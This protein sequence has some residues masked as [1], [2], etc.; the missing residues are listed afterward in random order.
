[1]FARVAVHE[2][3]GHRVDEA[4]SSFRSTS[5]DPAEHR[6]RVKPRPTEPVDRAVAAHEGRG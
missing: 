4:A 2:I 5:Q 1:M 6:R 3:P